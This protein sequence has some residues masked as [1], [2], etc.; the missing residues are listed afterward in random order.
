MKTAIFLMTSFLIPLIN[1]V[2]QPTGLEKTG[3]ISGDCINGQ[4][5]FVYSNGDQYI[6]NFLN[7]KK[8]GKGKY[9]ASNGDRYEGAFSGGMFE[10][11]GIYF[12]NSGKKYEGYW[13]K[14]RYHGF[15]RI[16]GPN[17]KTEKEGTWENG[18]LIFSGTEEE[19]AAREEEIYQELS[20]AFRKSDADPIKTTERLGSQFTF[21]TESCEGLNRYVAG[22]PNSF[23]GLYQEDQGKE[24]VGMMKYPVKFSLFGISQGHFCIWNNMN[25]ISFNTG[26]GDLEEQFSRLVQHID[27]C[28]DDDWVKTEITAADG[29]TLKKTTYNY[30]KSL[31]VIALTDY[32]YKRVLD[33]SF[34]KEEK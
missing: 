29:Q 26:N 16:I 34:R 32:K 5:T 33:L 4:G 30:G 10:G 2:G 25:W 27:F 8:H 23:N 9:F 11:Y 15:G 12:F 18:I 14:N 13:K 3:C 1:V 21:S 7:G 17:G 20:E 24:V 19:V 28:L 22:I 6:G 31:I